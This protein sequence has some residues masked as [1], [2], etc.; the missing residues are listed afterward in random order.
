MIVAAR[1]SAL[2]I[3]ENAMTA[4]FQ[5]CKNIELAARFM[6]KSLLPRSLMQK[7]YSASPSHWGR[8]SLVLSFL[9]GRVA[10][11]SLLEAL[12]PFKNVVHGCMRT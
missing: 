9:A 6:D 10:A 3:D 2:T 8:N 4:S 11:V 7:A 5:F 12:S 1:Q